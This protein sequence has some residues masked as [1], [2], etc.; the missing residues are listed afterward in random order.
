MKD[1]LPYSGEPIS[2]DFEGLLNQWWNAKYKYL[3]THLTGH[4]VIEQREEAR[5]LYERIL[6][7]VHIA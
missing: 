5:I 2:D 3:H 6:S 4:K 1:I 7:L